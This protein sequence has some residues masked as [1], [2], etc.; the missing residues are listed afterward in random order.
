MPDL[1]PSWW[2]IVLG[3]WV[4]T[5]AVCSGLLAR[6]ARKSERSPEDR[7]LPSLDDE[8]LVARLSAL[9]SEKRAPTTPDDD[10]LVKVAVAFVFA[11]TAPTLL[12]YGLGQALW[13]LAHGEVPLSRARLWGRPDVEETGRSSA[14]LVDMIAMRRRRD[15]ALR[16]RPPPDQWPMAALWPTP[17]GMVL[18]I[19]ELHALLQAEGL[20]DQQAIERIE[21]WR[22]T[23]AVAPG[24]PPAEIEAYVKFRLLLEAPAYP[25]ENAKL[26]MKVIARAK[27]YAAAVLT[28]TTAEPRPPVDWLEEKIRLADL[29]CETGNAGFVNDKSG[30][31]TPYREAFSRIALRMRDGDE[32]WTFTSP[33]ETW[34]RRMGRRGVT[35]VR[36]GKAIEHVVLEM[37]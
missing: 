16:G 15:P 4:A 27:A 17:E 23:I 6:P 11:V 21:T 18:E 32:L 26:L 7:E 37:N 33:P 5:S 30:D 25:V 34:R 1:E 13:M 24:P 9:F 14:A 12:L 22:S 35:L 28:N 36:Q 31:W 3:V 29:G 10:L 20:T 19:V 8:E 2:W